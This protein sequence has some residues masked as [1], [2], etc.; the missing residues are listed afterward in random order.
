LPDGVSGLKATGVRLSIEDVD[1]AELT[2]LI[3]ARFAGAAPVGYLVGRT[4]LRDA[5]AEQ[6]ECSTLEAEEIVDTLVAR[7]F[8]RYEGDPS[9]A[10]DDGRGWSLGA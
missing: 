7:G 2:A 5:V 8:L 3:R 9:A 6:L 10:L 4:A 1:L